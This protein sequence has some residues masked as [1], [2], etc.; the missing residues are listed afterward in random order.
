MVCRSSASPARPAGD[1]G[2]ADEPGRPASRET[3]TETRVA[4]DSVR[5]QGPSA[6]LVRA[7]LYAV[8]VLLALGGIVLLFHRS[9]VPW[10]FHYSKP[11]VLLLT[12]YFTIVAI[13]VL[14][15]RLASPIL[16]AALGRP[17]IRG[18]VMV[19]VSGL[20]ALATAEAA[21]V[22]L[23]VRLW[24]P[25]AHHREG[26][27]F[28][29][30]DR[31]LHHVR[32]AG[33]VA[34]IVSPY[35]EYQA[36]VRINDDS[37]R[38]VERPVAKPQGTF[39][40]LMLGDSLTE[41]EQVSLEETFAKRLERELTQSRGHTVDV[42]N[43]GLAAASPTTEYLML[44]NKGI[45]YAPDLVVCAYSLIGVGQDW[46]YRNE[47]TFDAQGVPVERSQ[48]SR[49]LGGD[50]FYALYAYSRLAQMLV[51]NYVRVRRRATADDLMVSIFDD[52]DTPLEAEAWNLTLRTIRAMKQ[53][54][55][56]H[57]AR[58]LLIAI[59]FATQVY[60]EAQIGN[61]RQVK[62]PD[63][64]RTSRRP[65]EM[66]ERFSRTN[67]IAYVDLLP[68]FVV[69]RDNAPLFFRYD[70][71]LTPA[72]HQVIASALARFLGTGDDR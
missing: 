34:N 20:L 66:L 37:L 71:H 45:K 55:E 52:E 64:V 39:R 53:Y 60:P 3:V 1:E 23:P 12:A 25:N 28:A 17:A 48:I 15:G 43:A 62:L 21:L 7:L 29:R 27:I 32:P 6:E 18:L 72:G 56:A 26:A 30:P 49:G 69:A 57:G 59:P 51:G 42:I 9:N 46:Q 41:A 70:T 2:I 67:G 36:E 10:L 40:I 13:I 38:D 31:Q 5:A 44:I 8:A 54:S 61:E 68:D 35:G 58:F 33:T 11:Y 65:Q 24:H 16:A 19:G 22:M 14:A 4:H 63:T 50:V 47:M